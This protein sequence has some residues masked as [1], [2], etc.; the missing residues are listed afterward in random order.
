M[1][2]LTTRGEESQTYM[3]LMAE[4][5]KSMSYVCVRAHIDW[6]SGGSRGYIL[7]W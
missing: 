7:D 2:A 6:I 3:K 5:G 1:H 4:E